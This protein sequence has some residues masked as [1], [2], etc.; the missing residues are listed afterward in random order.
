MKP[1]RLARAALDE[2]AAA[3]DWYEKNAGLGTDLVHAVRAAAHQIA[4]RPASFP[5]AHGVNPS[6]GVRRCSVDRFPYAL[7]FVELDA[8]FRVIAVAH[9]RRKP[10]YWRRRQ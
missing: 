4:E 9:V 6:A 10:G 5:L 3:E 8:E 2:L 7:F 1:V